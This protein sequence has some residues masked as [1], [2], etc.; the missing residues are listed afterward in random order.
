MPV[1]RNSSKI[2]SLK[3]R[4]ILDS[5]GNPTLEVELKTEAFS[6][7]ASVPSGASKGKYE[8]LELRDGGKRYKGK[9]VLKAIENVNK[10]IFPK[11]K[12]MDVR[13]QKDIDDLMAELDG[14]DSKSNLGA[15][16]I[17]SVSLAVARAGAEAEKLPLYR[18]I[19]KIAG[20]RS[21]LKIP[22]PCFNII[23]GGAHAEN[24]LDIQEFMIIP[25][26]KDKKE[27]F[28]KSLQM[29]SEIY[30]ELKKMIGRKYSGLG[31]NVG[32]E[33][34][35]APPLRNPEE[36][37]QLILNAS[38]TLGYLEKIKIGLDCASSKFFKQGRYGMAIGFFTRE[39][40]LRYYQ[41]L[42]KKYPILFLEDPFAEEDWQGFTEITKKLG[43]KIEIVGDDL[44]ATDSKRIKEAYR[45]KACNAVILKL[46]QIGTVSE[47]IQSY[48][49]AHSFGWK[50]IVSHR[51]GETCDNFISDFAVGIGSDFIKSGAPARGERVSKYNQL[52]R[53]EEQLKSF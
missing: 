17:L 29:S 8:A 53:I 37:I 36:A 42:V 4:E 40:L 45:K 25:Q 35:F 20:N 50:T 23:N 13:K 30:H 15:N 46:N 27:R 48:K 44:L 26:I 32:D 22:V 47:T 21:S 3:V 10:K 43:R 52:L 24:D 31:T 7:L 6:V 41:E 33:G 18:Y 34:G 2:K 28:K 38:K 51:S 39:G 11:I 12:G 1:L 9:G 14:T 16:A 49:L 5:R 19:A